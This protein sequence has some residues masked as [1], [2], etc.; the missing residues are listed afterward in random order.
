MD[1]AGFDVFGLNEQHFLRD[2]GV[3][4]SDVVFAF[5]A[6]R[7]SRIRLRFMSV[8]LLTFNHPVRVAERLAMLDVLSEGRAEMSTARSNNLHTLEAFGVQPN[9]TRAQWAE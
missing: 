7:T 4:A 5:V 2:I 3:S 8:L 9:E 6:A 1:E